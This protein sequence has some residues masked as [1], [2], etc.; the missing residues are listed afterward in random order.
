MAGGGVREVAEVEE[1][2]PVLARLVE[3]LAPGFREF[4]GVRQPEAVGAA[5]EG[6]EGG[7]APEAVGRALR[8]EAHGLQEL[9]AEE[10]PGVAQVRARKLGEGDGRGVLGPVREGDGL[11]GEGVVHD[12]GAPARGA[13]RGDLCRR[14]FAD[15][16][17]ALRVGRRQ[18]KGHGRGR[19][20][21][22][23]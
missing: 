21:N 5:L 7:L 3:G 23:G 13:E 9:H 17:V 22:A 16:L 6:E 8:L 4:A 14:R 12:E 15:P 10:A 2:A 11:V 18:D 20:R 19:G 1:D